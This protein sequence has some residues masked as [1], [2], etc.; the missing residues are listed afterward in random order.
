MSIYGFEGPWDGF[1]RLRR[2]LMG[3]V[4][5]PRAGAP[6]PSAAGVFPPINVY[7]TGE[8]YVLTAEVPGLD[9]EALEVTVEGDQVTLRG[10]RRDERPEGS[11]H[12]RERQVG[13]FARWQFQGMAASL[14]EG[15]ACGS[16]LAGRT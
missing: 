8:G 2:E 9:R 4:D 3:L 12:R 11:V 15:L 6:A 1:D 5:R 7:A 10:E 14:A 16:A 13:R